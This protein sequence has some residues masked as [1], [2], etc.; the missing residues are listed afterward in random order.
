MSMFPHTVTVYNIVKEVDPDTIKTVTNVYITVL[1]GV[2]LSASKGAIVRTSG[3][4]GADAVIL[5]IPFSVEAVDGLTGAPKEYVE[6]VAFWR[7]DDKTGVW[8]LRTGL[9]DCFVKGNVIV[10]DKADKTIQFLESA[11]DDVYNIT[12]LDMMDYGGSMAHW[13]VGGV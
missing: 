3:L 6:P 5:Y 7:M 11:Y 9:D 2:F 1:K 12:K 8:T 13:E 10:P 4:E